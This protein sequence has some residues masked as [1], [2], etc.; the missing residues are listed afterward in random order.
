M[1]SLVSNR[2]RG[3]LLEVSP[4]QR[5]LAD[6]DAV[7]LTFDDGPDPAYTPHVL[8]V[9]AEQG[10][11]ATFFVIASRA[12]RYPEL[13]RR[14]R[15]AGHTVASHGWEHRHRWWQSRR[16]AIRN[17]L[18]AGRALDLLCSEPVGWYR[19]AFGCLGRGTLEAAARQGQRVVLWSRSAI[20]WGPWGTA[21]AV[22]RRLGRVQG[23]DIV[24]MHDAPNRYNRPDATIQALPAAIESMRRR[25]LRLVALSETVSEYPVPQ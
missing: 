21:A 7:A 16:S 24:L 3:A 18:K 14:M 10:V 1:K 5:F 9:L 12:E 13:I 19:P 2:A 11:S 8:G 23:G 22:A 15:E 4:P 25:G 17:I 20:D 6:R